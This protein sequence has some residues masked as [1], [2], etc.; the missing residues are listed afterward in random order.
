M[1]SSQ[2]PTDPV[3]RVL[4]IIASLSLCVMMLVVV[5]DVVLRAVFNFPIKGAYDIVSISLLVTIM[6]GLAPV[7]A[8]RGEI[9]IDLIDV[10][11]PSGG[12]RFLALVSALTGGGLFLFFGWAMINP[13]LDSWRWGERSLELNLPKWPL[14]GITFIGMLAVFWA[15]ILQF[16]AALRNAPDTPSQEG[17]L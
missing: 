11:L 2:Y 6:F 1:N 17:G 4:L 13:A 9:L 7:V 10:L 8:Q 3:S 5:G 12:L 14:W 15:Y 16:R